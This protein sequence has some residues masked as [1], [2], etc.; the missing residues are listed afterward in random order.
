VPSQKITE[1][2]ADKQS[3]MEK[4]EI[5]NKIEKAPKTVKKAK[6]EFTKETYDFLHQVL[7]DFAIDTK[8]RPQLKVILQNAKAEPKN[9][10][11]I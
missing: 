2:K 5:E 8:H 9:N 7:V 11:S 10:S 4:V 6:D 1:A 3:K